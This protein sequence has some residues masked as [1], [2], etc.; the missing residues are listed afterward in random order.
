MNPHSATHAIQRSA[1]YDKLWAKDSKCQSAA[2]AIKLVLPSPSVF[3]IHLPS[4]H[5]QVKSEHEI[6]LMALILIPGYAFSLSKF[7]SSRKSL[8][9]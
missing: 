8:R 4:F 2:K 3:C 1:A 7:T 9:N 6:R 5:A